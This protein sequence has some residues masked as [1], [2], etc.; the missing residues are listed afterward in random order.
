MVTNYFLGRASILNPVINLHFNPARL[1]LQTGYGDPI[2]SLSQHFFRHMET[3]SSDCALSF[4]SIYLL[5]IIL[6]SSTQE[7]ISPRRKRQRTEAGLSLDDPSESQP[8]KRLKLSIKLH[9]AEFYNSLSKAWLTHRALK[10]LDRRTS[11]VHDPKRP[12]PAHQQVD[13]EDTWKKQIQRFARHGGP[14]L[15]D[16]RGVRPELPK[17]YL[18]V[19]NHLFLV[20]NTT[21]R[22]PCTRNEL[23]QLSSERADPIYKTDE[24][25]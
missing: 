20:S 14:E 21:K 25:F 9:S 3:Y 1:H 23:Q 5:I 11:Q 15:R 19:S 16:L 24:Q 7:Q 4:L 8:L 6:M 10:E 13:R 22:R 12:A 2:I 17:A 18:F